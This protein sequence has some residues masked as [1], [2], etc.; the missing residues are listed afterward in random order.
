[1]KQYVNATRLVTKIKMLRSGKA[2]K[3]FV[4]VEGI[5]DHRLYSKFV[6]QSTCEMII[7]DSKSN[8]LQCIETCNDEKM[9]GIVG[10]VD[11]DFWR[12]EEQNASI[13]NVF[14]TDYH[15]LE[16][17]LIHSPAYDSV[18]FEYANRNKYLRFEEKRKRSVREIILE[19]GAKI[20][21]LRWYSL[22]NNLGL[23]FS[24]LDFSRFVNPE[25][26]EVDLI[27]LVEYILVH[28]KKHNVFNSSQ[29]VKE[30][31]SFIKNTNSLWDV[32][33]GHDLI[34]ILTIGF[35]YIFGEYNAK[36]LFSG[37]LEG[38]F[39]LAY[40]YHSFRM[41]NLYKSLSK[42]EQINSSYSLFEHKKSR[43]VI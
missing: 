37:N 7:A 13:N 18:L 27:K 35:I 34:E 12:L 3:S 22:Q 32:C 17:M 30:L 21:Y 5:T 29:I 40:D 19:S 24:G 39:R 10:I 16:C 25:N 15:D 28:S 31:K 11:A 43:A 33:C 20:G 23:K 26:L 41:S 9:K 6:V 8:V 14:L 42:W 36:N 38:S 4:V 2:N 1:M